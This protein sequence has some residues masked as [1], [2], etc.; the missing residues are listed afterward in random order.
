[1]STTDAQIAANQANA[2]L[3]TGPTTEAGKEKVRLN[4]LKTGL[5]GHTVLL[6]TDD[7]DQY[8]A[9]IESFRA[10]HDPQGD[11]ETRL[12]QSIAD[13]TWR[14]QRVPVLECAIYALGHA[15]LAAL[16][17]DIKDAAQRQ[18]MIQCE[19]F[20]AYER[21]LRNLQLQESRL[22]RN[23][24]KDAAALKALQE[25]RKSQAGARLNAAAKQ[26][27]D[28]IKN[29]QGRHWDAKQNGFEF[30]TAEIEQRAAKIDPATVNHFIA[31]KPRH[32]R[33]N[34]A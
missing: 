34:A 18:A 33:N 7:A 10:E 21:Q 30:S 19:V 28:A 23:L 25:Q 6:P 5:T 1:M 12:V 24:E 14:L 29:G 27:I 11:A 17:P 8:A 15:K 2:Q 31:S 3:S 26:L 4:A 16:H 20:L 13:T 32:L 22:R 9:L